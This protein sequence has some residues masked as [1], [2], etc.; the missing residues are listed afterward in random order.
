MIDRKILD[1]QMRDY[2]RPLK[3][4]SEI[5]QFSTKSQRWEEYKTEIEE[6]FLRESNINRKL[7]KLLD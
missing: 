3:R 2:D 5:R 1:T 4:S 7:N 6:K